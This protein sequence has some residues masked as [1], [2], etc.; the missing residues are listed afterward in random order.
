MADGDRLVLIVE[1]QSVSPGVSVTVSYNGL[2]AR[3]EG[4]SYI[5]CPD[6]LALTAQ[7]PEPTR[8]AIRQMIQDVS[9]TN[10]NLKDQS[11]DQA[12]HQAI[13]DYTRDSPCIES[14]YLSGDGASRSFQMPRRWVLGLSSMQEIEYPLDTA[15]GKRLLLDDDSWEITEGVLGMQ[16]TRSL[17]FISVVPESGTNNILVRYTTR[18]VHTDDENTISGQDLDAVVCLA[19]SYCCLQLAAHAASTTS[20]TIAAD[21][22]V[23]RDMAS[24]WQSLAK[25]LK[26]KY[27]EHVLGGGADT[28][29]GAASVTRDWDIYPSIPGTDF[30]F[31]K[32]GSH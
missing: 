30:L 10:P 32:K 5:I 4:D 19:A 3:S 2:R 8:T 11:V 22:V 15:T 24:Q 7:Y 17:R 14:E 25:D 28:P 27:T 12:L 31:H 1:A 16:P 21:V 26:A 29:V 9:Q 18:H 20:P 6:S 23:G 13:R